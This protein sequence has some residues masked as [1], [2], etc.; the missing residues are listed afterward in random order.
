MGIGTFFC[1]SFPPRGSGLLWYIKLLIS[2]TA[3][4]EFNQEKVFLNST[5]SASSAEKKTAKMRLQTIAIAVGALATLV[6]F[7]ILIYPSS[8]LN[9]LFTNTEVI[10]PPNGGKQNVTIGALLPLTGVGINAGES[11]DV[12]IR[13]AIKD[14]NKYFRESNSNIRIGLIIENT[15][16]DPDISREKLK[17]LAAQ[18]VKI[19]IGPA[20]STEL[21]KLQDDAHKRGI[22]LVSQSSTCTLSRYCRR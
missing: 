8:S 14:V 2:S 6:L 12:A 11:E 4:Y 16:T 20:S 10:P 3:T 22:L 19:V 15:R 7:G 5:L 13:I 18:G 9:P 17:D 21:Q 1:G